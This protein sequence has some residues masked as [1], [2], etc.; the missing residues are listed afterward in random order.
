M[1]LQRRR[2]PTY[3][4]KPGSYISFEKVCKSFGDFVVLEDVS[5]CVN[6]G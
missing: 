1:R 3:R 2:F 5:F 4:N 6:A